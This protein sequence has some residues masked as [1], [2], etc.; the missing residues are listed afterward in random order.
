MPATIPDLSFNK[1]KWLWCVGH[2]LFP[3]LVTPNV[4]NNWIGFNQIGLNWLCVCALY[5]F[6]RCW[7]ARS[8]TPVYFQ[9]L[10]KGV[11]GEDAG[12]R[13]RR[14][15]SLPQTGKSWIP[16][17]WGSLILRASQVTRQAILDPFWKHKDFADLVF[18]MLQHRGCSLRI[19]FICITDR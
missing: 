5:P 10:L 13:M 16:G 15:G 6:P 2:T 17:K 19:I 1:P 8:V 18:V 3:L 14:V 12:S 7:S 4:N 9:C 11:L